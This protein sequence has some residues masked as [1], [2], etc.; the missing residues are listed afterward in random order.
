V[1]S[2]GLRPTDLSLSRSVCL[3]HFSHIIQHLHCIVLS[4]FH[5]LSPYSRTR[6]ILPNLTIHPSCH[7]ILDLSSKCIATT[8]YHNLHDLTAKAIHCQTLK[9][10]PGRPFATE[11][12]ICTTV[13]SAHPTLSASSP[14]STY[15]P[16]TTVASRCASRDLR[17]HN[18][19]TP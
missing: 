3:C 19:H 16:T 9:H 5:F 17:D 12:Q 7:Y 6:L 4:F 2:R 13:P 1:K 8:I 18:R 11:I 15:P 10:N 14:R